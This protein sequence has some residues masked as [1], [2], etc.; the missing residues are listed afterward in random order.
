MC[1][2][3]L[4]QVCLETFAY[5]VSPTDFSLETFALELSR[6]NHRFHSFALKRSLRNSFVRNF[7]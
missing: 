5:Q 4:G 3:L 6:G 1:G 2:Y 7:Q